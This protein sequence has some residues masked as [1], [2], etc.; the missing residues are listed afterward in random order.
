MQ[1]KILKNYN[2]RIPEIIKL[3]WNIVVFRLV[4]DLLNMICLI[5]QLLYKLH[6]YM[7]FRMNLIQFYINF[8]RY[9]HQIDV[10]YGLFKA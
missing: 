10:L 6:M 9:E 5:L 2:R 1:N 7:I 8:S 4:V 3:L